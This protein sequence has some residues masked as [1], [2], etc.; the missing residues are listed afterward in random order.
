MGLA[1][2]PVPVDIVATDTQPGTAFEQIGGFIVSVRM[3]AYGAILVSTRGPFNRNPTGM[4]FDAQ[5]LGRSSQQ[6]RLLAAMGT[7]TQPALAFFE[8]IMTAGLLHLGLHLLMTG[9]ADLGT[10]ATHQPLAG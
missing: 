6:K 7:M 3:V 4:A 2:G 5:I 9:G 8:R 10:I 1:L